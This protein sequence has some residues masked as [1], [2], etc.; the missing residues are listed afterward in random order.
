MGTL[1][2]TLTEWVLGGRVQRSAWG[3]HMP[4]ACL[5][6]QEPFVLGEKNVEI[7]QNKIQQQ[8]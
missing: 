6:V 1:S 8:Q 7:T 5:S 2:G 3:H 4:A